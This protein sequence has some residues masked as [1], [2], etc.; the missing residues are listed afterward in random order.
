M[1]FDLETLFENGCIAYEIRIGEASIIDVITTDKPCH[2]CNKTLQ[3]RAKY[4]YG[5]ASTKKAVYLDL[6]CFNE[7]RL[8][9][10]DTLG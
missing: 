2:F 4:V 9:E 3:G 1:G 10:R 7:S 8:G 5:L 6:Y